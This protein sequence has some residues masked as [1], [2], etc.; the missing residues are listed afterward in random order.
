[1]VHVSETVMYCQCL[2]QRPLQLSGP[3]PQPQ[4]KHPQP[5]QQ[6]VA[7]A[8]LPQQ[9][10][11]EPSA[12]TRTPLPSSYSA[13][14]PVRK[15]FVPPRPA[16]TT[17]TL[18]TDVA[19]EEPGR[20]L[21]AWLDLDDN[22]GDE[23]KTLS[24]APAVLEPAAISQQAAQ[25]TMSALRLPRFKRPLPNSGAPKTLAASEHLR[26]PPTA[27]TNLV[28]FAV[29]VPSG[30]KNP[31]RRQCLYARYTNAES[32]AL[33]MATAV[34]EELQLGVAEVMAHAEKV[35]GELLRGNLSGSMQRGRILLPKIEEQMIKKLRSVRL[36]HLMSMTRVDRRT[37]NLTIALFVCL[38]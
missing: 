37:P 3:K 34:A 28:D 10:V 1:V 30:Y 4:L 8:A 33:T 12:P 5:P 22:G 21:Y 7:T 6:T 15:K 27:W 32:Y 23:G 16:K 14:G 19:A 24:V 31:C 9:H 38:S 13:S 29:D 20:D 25:L 11:V 17:P 36:L 2:V 35:A 26:L 18:T